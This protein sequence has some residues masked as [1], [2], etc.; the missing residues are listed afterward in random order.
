MKKFITHRFYFPM[1]M[2]LSLSPMVFKTIHNE[3]KPQVERSIASLDPEELKKMPKPEHELEHSSQARLH[4]KGGPGGMMPKE[5]EK[6]PEQDIKKEEIKV[7]KYEKESF[8]KDS[9]KV[10]E[11]LSS[12]ERQLLDVVLKKDKKFEQSLHDIV[13]EQFAK[14]D[15]LE[16]VEADSEAD[17]KIISEKISELRKSANDMCDRL[18]E[19]AASTKYEEKKEEVAKEE[20]KEEPCDLQQKYSELSKQVEAMTADHKKYLDVIV[21]M[22]QMMMSMYQQQQQPQYTYSSGPF[23]SVYYPY[24]SS[25][26]LGQVTNNYYYSGSNWQQPQIMGIGQYDQ[27]QGQQQ[28][29]PQIQQQQQQGQ[30]PSI[31]MQGQGMQQP[32]MMMMDPRYSSM[33]VMPGVFGDTSFMHNFG[34]VTQQASPMVVDT[35]R[36]PAV[37]PMMNSI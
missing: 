26:G 5:G 9:A 24:H 17:K 4:L 20:K 1:A 16:K 34:G 8:E 2:V 37:L 30:Q 21:G 11:S 25:N 10:K 27:Q 31:Q 32:S 35:G 15:E 14:I 12:V 22:N 3:V 13:N 18:E 29:A 7:I 19:V 28:V 6:K 23:G 36:S 33:N